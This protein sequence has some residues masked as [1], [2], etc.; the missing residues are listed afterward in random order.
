MTVARGARLHADAAWGGVLLT[1]GATCLSGC[2]LFYTFEEP[3]A[4]DD[5]GSASSTATGSTGGGGDDAGVASSGTTATATATTGSGGGGGGTCIRH[6]SPA[7]D[8]AS[9]GCSEDAPM[10]TISGAFERA[11]GTS[12]TEIRVC[13]GA[14]DEALTIDAPIQLLGG[15][16]C[17]TWTKTGMADTT[18]VQA[19]QGELAAITA[20][21]AAVDSTSRLEDLT[22]RGAIDTPFGAA[23]AIQDGSQVVVSRCV[24]EGGSGESA[25]AGPSPSVTVGVKIDGGASPELDGCD[26]HGGSGVS[27]SPVTGSTG[28]VAGGASVHVHDCTIDGGTG[29]AQSSNGAASVGAQFLAGVQIGP[30]RF[31]RNRVSGGDGVAVVGAI[32]SLG[33]ATATPAELEIAD[34][35]IAVGAGA[36]CAR[37]GECRAGALVHNGVVRV[38]RTRFSNGSSIGGNLVLVAGTHASFEDC[39]FL[40]HSGGAGTSTLRAEGLGSLRLIHSALHAGPSSDEGSVI[41][42][43]AYN[44][45]IRIE[46]NILMGNGPGSV[47]FDTARCQQNTVE[48]FRNNVLVGADLALATFVPENCAGYFAATDVAALEATLIAEFGLTAEEVSGNLVVRDSCGGEPSCIA[49]PACTSPLACAAVVLPGFDSGSLAAFDADGWQL[50]EGAPCAVV[51]GGGPVSNRATDLFGVARTEP[52]SMGASELDTDT[53]PP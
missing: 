30:R 4:G 53:C 31:E 15:F 14:Y 39:L 19:P 45:G 34:C 32:A 29:A 1:T 50:A 46:G 27:Y 35:S 40:G 42:A 17:A 20:T 25:E 7:G 2:F 5:A 33:I 10:R 8:D 44:S 26:I 21:G 52:T 37:E 9:E 36:S 13:A 41:T 22:M 48:I 11:R 47:G 23:L 16:D 6:V 24:I 49:S 51:N 18:V 3:P 28:L 38:V 12:A 43:R